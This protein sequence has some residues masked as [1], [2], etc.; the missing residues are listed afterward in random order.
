MNNTLASRRPVPASPPK[1][2]WGWLAL[3]VIAL[4]LC[5]ALALVAVGGYNLL[6]PVQ[7][8]GPLVFF[9]SP[10]SG[11]LL[12]VGSPTRVQALARD[13]RKVTRLELWVDGALHSAQASNLPGGIS[14]F[15]LMADWQP[16][17]PGSHTLTARA[18][19]GRGGRAQATIVVE[20]VPVADRD[21]DGTPDEA[22][23]CPDQPGG[24]IA[25]GCP[26]GDGDGIADGSDACPAESGLPDSDGCPAPSAAD[27]D[28]DGVLD[29]SDACP[30]EAGAPVAGGCPDA[31]GDG[32]ADHDDA[33]PAEP[34]PA[35]SG[36]CP[37]PAAEPPADDGGA[38]P[39]DRDGD[40]VADAFDLCPDTPGVPHNAGCPE[41][42]GDTDGDGVSDEVDLCPDEPGL[43]EHGGC[44][45]PGAGEDSDGD[46]IPDVEEP[47]DD[48]LS[49][50]DI[51]PFIPEDE[52]LATAIQ[53]QALEFQLNESYDTLTCY[54]GLGGLDMDRMGPFDIAGA[55]RWD[56]VASYGDESYLDL[57][58]RPDEPLEVH[59]SCGAEVIDMGPGGG[60]G[61]YFDLG[62]ISQQHPP[63][64][65]DGHVITVSSTDSPDGRSFQASYRICQPSCD[66]TAMPAP[67]LTLFHVGNDHRLIWYWNGDPARRA[68]Y[69][70]YL[71]GSHILSAPTGTYSLSVGDFEP[72]CGERYEFQMSVY[73]DAG[74]ESALSNVAYW[75]APAC[76]RW[77]QVTF[78]SLDV[79]DP[80]AD[81]DGLHRP[82]PIYGGF[83]ASTDAESQSLDF[84]A[85]WCYFGP[86][87]TFWG[88]CEG[89]KLEHGVYTI[90]SIFDWIDTQMLEC[91]GG[92]CHSNSFNAPGSNV[93]TLELPPGD[94]LTL[95][96]NIMDCDERSN[97]NDTLFN[98]QQGLII[99]TGG[100]VNPP[101]IRWVLRGDYVD[102]NMVISILSEER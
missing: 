68:G 1:R 4:G 61:A 88:W 83:Y 52:P 72:P 63:S 42:G 16:D 3:P 66:N 6:Q 29:E 14:S 26:D 97:P 71:N 100:G 45:P 73:D 41:G 17:T 80:P 101:P 93:V 94:V 39:S 47:T 59:A 54:A 69:K 23:A 11:Q 77:A 92:G 86:G 43:P 53:F 95:G 65:W 57:F 64:D 36:G 60:W 67:H 50:W 75:T 15:P 20:A 34:G 9:R 82:G 46:G 70:F 8:A 32:I 27:R 102:V 44:P 10:A 51:D 37:S 98:G 21:Q 7:Q 79:H 76:R 18:F 40:G 48:P 24:N 89:L 74:Q 19:N 33:C 62:D 30:D 91:F 84:D 35:E 5:C 81:E 2:R 56:L 78:E 85:C 87:M 99:N 90:P 58:V 12:Q 28:G 22:D 25:Q 13:E 38:P 49:D 96:A 55:R 31:D